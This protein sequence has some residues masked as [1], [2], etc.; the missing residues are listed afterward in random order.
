MIDDRQK[1]EA[2]QILKERLDRRLTAYLEVCGRCALCAEACHYYVSEPKPEHTANYRNDQVRRVYRRQYDWVGRVF[3]AWVGARDLD[4]DMIETLIDAAF[5]TCTMCRRCSLNCMMGVDVGAMM[6]TA[7]GMLAALGRVPEGLQATVDVHLETGNNMGISEEDFVETLEWMEEELQAELDDPTAKIPINKKGARV[8][9]TFNPREIKY[10]PLSIQAVAKIFHAAGENWTVSTEAWDVTNYA[11]FSGDDKAARTIARRLVDAV[12]KIGA[13]WLIMA[14][15][16]HGFRALRWEGENWLGRQVPFWIRG[17]VPVMAEYI[18]DGRL[19][20]DPSGHTQLVTY[21]DPCNQA[22]NGGIVD[23]PRYILAHT[24][25]R[26]TEMEPHGIYNYCCGGG[27]GMLAMTEY[28]KRRIRVGKIK[29]D[30]IAA[31]GAE[32]VATSCHN[33]LDQLDEIKR[34][35]KLKVKIQNLSE[36]VADAI[37]WPREPASAAQAEKNDG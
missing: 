17:F 7:R 8:V 24:V 18:Q 12:E 25:Q 35:Y 2:L 15:C 21:H 20:L 34:H 26:F 30:Q 27:G 29:A 33:C 3:P 1:R 19:H 6:R 16:G 5:G 10:Y 11:L 28:A 4:E 23:E 31:T 37:I 14:E 32:V 22:R 9:Y 13:R 36:L